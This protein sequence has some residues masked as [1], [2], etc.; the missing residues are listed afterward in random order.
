MKDC[1]ARGRAPSVLQ[2][3]QDLVVALFADVTG[4]PGSPG[5]LVVDLA[6]FDAGLDVVL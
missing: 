4:R 3:D 5:A 6:G 1:A 2:L